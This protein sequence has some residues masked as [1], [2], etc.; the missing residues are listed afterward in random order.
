VLYQGS[1]AIWDWS[2][3]RIGGER[4]NL[5]PP[6]PGRRTWAPFQSVGE[7]LFRAGFAGLLAPSA[8]RP[9]ALIS[10]VFDLGAWPPDGCR[11]IK[12]IEINEA[13]APP[14]GMTT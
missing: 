12:A 9:Q 11:P 8:A 4:L 7:Q 5:E 6:R 3:G 14:T 2:S 13:P 1:T 10:C